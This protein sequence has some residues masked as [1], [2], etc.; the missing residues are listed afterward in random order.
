MDSVY[1]DDDYCDYMKNIPNVHGQYVIYEQEDK[2][3]IQDL[4]SKTK[5][6]IKQ[7]TCRNPCTDTFIMFVCIL[8]ESN[9]KT[10]NSKSHRI[11]MR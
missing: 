4:L 10:V 11:I 1:E 2:K 6:H 8:A 5:V 7:V 3:Y 9:K